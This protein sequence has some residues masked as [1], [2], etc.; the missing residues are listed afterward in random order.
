MMTMNSILYGVKWI[1]SI[2]LI[3]IIT[4][5]FLF[6]VLHL[7]FRL[8]DKN[9]QKKT[10]K[11]A[12]LLQSKLENNIDL[13][14]YEIKFLSHNLNLLVQCM[15]ELEKNMGSHS[16]WLA[17]KQQ[18]SNQVLKP[19]ARRLSSSRSWLKKYLAVLCYNEG[20]DNEDNIILSKL[21]QNDTLLLSLNTAK[22]IFKYPSIETIHALV[23]ALSKGRHPQQALF[24]EVLK[25]DTPGTKNYI[26]SAIIDKLH[27]EQ[28]PYAKAFC[29]Q[30]LT[31]LSATT[32]LLKTI[33]IDLNTHTLEL[34]LAAMRYL[35][36]IQNTE[37]CNILYGL[38]NDKE[39][40]V[41]AI[42]AKLLGN[43]HNEDSIAPL[44]TKLRDPAWWVRI[45]TANSLAKLGQKGILALERQSPMTDK[46]AYEIAQKVLITLRTCN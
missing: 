25:T 24:A 43:M 13:S 31:Q 26:I 20:I 16:T 1:T 22:V 34:R 21:I 2:Q 39:P 6:Y 30:I 28:D 42:A 36:N 15:D 11:I 35:P 29:Y 32:D 3:L 9:T 19:G 12:V 38:L 10:K 23:D 41:R 40:D 37:C 4:I 14:L 46:F 27:I 17:L 45:N 18:L 5:I 44:E 8:Y 33:Q 7:A